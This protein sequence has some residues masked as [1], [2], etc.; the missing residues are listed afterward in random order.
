MRSFAIRLDDFFSFLLIKYFL[1]TLQPTKYSINSLIESTWSKQKRIVHA[2]LP[3]SWLFFYN[4]DGSIAIRC[5]TYFL[6]STTVFSWVVLSFFLSTVDVYI[7]HFNS[8]WIRREC[9][10]FFLSFVLCTHPF[11]SIWEN[12]IQVGALQMWNLLFPC[13]QHCSAPFPLPWIRSMREGFFLSF[14]VSRLSSAR[15]FFFLLLYM[16]WSFKNR[17]FRSFIDY[18]YLLNKIRDIIELRQWL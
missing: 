13:P 1:M 4:F 15:W 9:L 16:F 7:V 8:L 18:G 12:I 6:Y 11:W 14:S 10:I 2:F 5:R 3:S 17:L